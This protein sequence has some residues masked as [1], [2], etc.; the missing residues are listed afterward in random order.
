MEHN[1]AFDSFELQF[2]PVAQSFIREAAKWAKF[3]SII[4]FI[5]IALYIL[6]A[7]M[8]IAGGAAMGANE[9]LN[10]ASGGMGM[11]GA[12]GGTALGIIYLIVAVIAIFPTLYLSRFAGKAKLALD[13]NNTEYLTTSLENLKSYFKFLGIFTIVMLVLMIIGFVVGIIAGV[14]AA[15]AM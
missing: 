15:G 6:V 7:L 8:M 5:F 10:T 12:I 13:N 9:E 1:S 14:S 3:L 4:G 2:T 11:M